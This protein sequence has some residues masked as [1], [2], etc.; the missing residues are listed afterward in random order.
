MEK[1]LRLLAED[2]SGSELARAAGKDAVTRDLALRIRA[3][4]QTPE[5]ALDVQVVLRLC[6]ALG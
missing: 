5:R 4:W 3:G 2:A 6:A 1:L